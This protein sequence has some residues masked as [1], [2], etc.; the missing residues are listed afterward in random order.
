[1]DE[2]QCLKEYLGGRELPNNEMNSLKGYAGKMASINKFDKEKLKSLLNKFSDTFFS[3]HFDKNIILY[4]R[5]SDRINE[6]F[7][8]QKNKSCNFRSIISLI[9]YQYIVVKYYTKFLGILTKSDHIDIVD[10]VVDI[11]NVYKRSKSKEYIKKISNEYVENVKVKGTEK[12][13]CNNEEDTPESLELEKVVINILKKSL[14]VHSYLIC[15]GSY[16]NHV[17]HNV[18]YD[19]IDVYFPD[20]F[21]YLI[22]IMFSVKMI[23]GYN[24]HILG[25][26]FIKGHLSILYKD[27]K[28]IDCIYI[29]HY[30]LNRIRTKEINSIKFIDPLFQFLNQIRMNNE[31]FRCNKIYDNPTKYTH[32]IY[33]FLLYIKDSYKGFDLRKVREYRKSSKKPTNWKMICDNIIMIDVEDFNNDNNGFDRVLVVLSDP[34]KI[35][36]ELKSVDGVYSIKYNA[37]LNEIF[38]ET[39]PSKGGFKNNDKKTLD[40]KKFG[41]HNFSRLIDESKKYLIMSSLTNTSYIDIDEKD[42]SIKNIQ[43]IIATIC[44]YS[45]LKDKNA[46]GWN[47]F[48]YLISTLKCKLEDDFEQK[49]CQLTRY[50]KNNKNS[51]HLILNIENNI[52][53]DF[54]TDRNEIIVDY[55]DRNDFISRYGND[56]GY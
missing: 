2:D 3:C 9:K 48:N 35:L 45:F 25:Y 36:E 33:S 47:I 11:S 20:S 23:T 52:F 26:P 4:T 53:N 22:L 49:Y 24:L 5:I 41:V 1:M 14:Y 12:K 37:F 28:L 46:Y 21:F 55:L 34:E 32:V 56:G 27:K 40:R 19:D 38:F 50:R 42:V 30:I 17:I 18:N 7:S 10:T 8:R 6:Y 31:L 51:K 13:K 15:Y 43:S 39:K 54:Q 29:S 44:L 16:T